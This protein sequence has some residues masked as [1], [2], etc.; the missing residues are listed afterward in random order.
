ME[1]VFDGLPQEIRKEADEDAR[2]VLFDETVL[3]DLLGVEESSLHT[4]GA[5]GGKEETVD[6]DGMGA[7]LIHTKGWVDLLPHRNVLV[8]FYEDVV[9]DLRGT[10]RKVARFMGREINEEQTELV[11]KRCSREYMMKDDRFKSVLDEKVFGINFLSAKVK[12]ADRDGFT[13]MSIRDKHVDALHA[14]M[15]KA[16]GVD[17]YEGLRELVARKQTQ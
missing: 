16:I 8:L 9:A 14:Q 7:W 6:E 5:F 11:A 15:K 13:K 3:Q 10:A 4:A 2:R 12:A 17:G 1:F